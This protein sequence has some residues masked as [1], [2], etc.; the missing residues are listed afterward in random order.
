MSWT[1]GLGGIIELELPIGR[2]LGGGVVY[3]EVL[4]CIGGGIFDSLGVVLD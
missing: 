4:S 1:R 2:V 3:C